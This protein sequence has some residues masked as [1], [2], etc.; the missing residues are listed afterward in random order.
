MRG[1]CSD[2]LNYKE[3]QVTA[4]GG[5]ILRFRRRRLEDFGSASRAYL[6]RF[7]V[8]V[9]YKVSGYERWRMQRFVGAPGLTFL[10]PIP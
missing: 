4:G 5:A 7:Q 9:Y 1:P 6:H 8:G 2:Y 3:N 10:N